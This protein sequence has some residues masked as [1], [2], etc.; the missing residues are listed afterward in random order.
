M[1]L[2][3]VNIFETG[4]FGQHPLGCIVDTFVG[5]DESPHKRPLS[6][7][8]FHLAFEQ[9]KIER[10]LLETEYDAIDR[11]IM[12]DFRKIITHSLFLE[13]GKRLM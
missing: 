7:S 12:F 9:Q 8:R 5:A 3:H 6:L 13:T 4:K 11:D 1:D 2:L 10:A